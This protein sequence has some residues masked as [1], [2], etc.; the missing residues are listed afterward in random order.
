MTGELNRNPTVR[1]VL[2]VC[3][4]NRLRSPTAVRVFA[5]EPGI[6]VRSAGVDPDAVVPLTSEHLEWAH[7]VLVM[8][9]R[10]RNVIQK[11]FPELYRTRR[12]VCLYIPDEF[13]YLDPVLMALLRE[14]AEPLLGTESDG[15]NTP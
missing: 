1:R 12:I 2:F 13:E 9:R 5:D 3:N 15:L 14:R 7:L 8:E 10:Q 11:R 6:E 4:Q